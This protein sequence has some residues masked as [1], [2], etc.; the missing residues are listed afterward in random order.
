MSNRNFSQATEI[1]PVWVLITF[2]LTSTKSPVSSRLISAGMTSS[3]FSLVATS[4]DSPF[5]INICTCP[6]IS[7]ITMNASLPN[8][9]IDITLP[10]TVTCWFSSVSKLDVI[11][12]VLCVRVALAGYAFTPRA[13]SSSS[14][15]SRSSLKSFSVAII[16]PILPHNPQ[17]CERSLIGDHSAI[18]PNQSSPAL[19]A[20]PTSPVMP[21]SH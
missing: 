4:A 17:Y 13:L 2:P 21:P 6:L 5:R 11:S 15:R 12:A 9:R 19:N 7:R 3:L 20:G 8:F 18:A 10:A 1:S 16:V 14:L